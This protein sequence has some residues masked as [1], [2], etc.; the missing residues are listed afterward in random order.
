MKRSFR[1]PLIVMTPKSLLRDKA[2]S[3]LEDFTKQS[4]QLVLDDPAE[5]IRSVCGGSF[6]ARASC[7]TRLMRRARRKT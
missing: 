1:K 5:P 4:F 6:C 2:F 7:S 3:P